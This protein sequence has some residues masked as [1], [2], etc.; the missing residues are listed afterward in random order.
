MSVSKFYQIELEKLLNE[1]NKISLFT[2]PSNNY[3][4]L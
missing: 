3:R 1:L 2:K 4:K